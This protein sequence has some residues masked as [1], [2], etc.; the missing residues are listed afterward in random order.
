MVI[1]RLVIKRMNKKTSKVKLKLNDKYNLG[2]KMRSDPGLALPFGLDENVVREISKIK[3]EPKWMLEFRLK[4]YHLF[5][6]KKMPS[7]GADLSKIDFS[8]IHY[9]IKSPDKNTKSWKNVSSEVKK[10][11]DR[12]GI[13]RVEREY[14][15]GVKAQ[16]NSEV[17]YGSLLKQLKDQ[18]VI[19]MSTDEAVQKHPD[20]VRKYIGT[21]IP[22]ADNKFAA[23][24]SAVW[25]GGSFIYI[26]KGAKIE[27][28]LQAYFRINAARMGQFERTL[29]IADEDSFT[30]Y[31]EGCSAPMY[32]ESSI[33]SAVVEIIVKKNARFRYTTV[34]NW[35]KNIY[36]LVTKR[37]YAY[38]NATMEW[39]DGNIGSKV[40]MKY[41]AVYLLGKGAKG[42]VISLAVAKDGQHLDTG[43]KMVHLA[44]NTSSNIISK[45]IS[46]GSGRA[47][48]RGLVKVIGS[49]ENVKSHI[50]C[51]ALLLD[52]KA[53]TDTYPSMEIDNKRTNITHEATVSKVGQDQLFYLMSRGLSKQDASA[54]I[55]NGFIEPVMRELPMEFAVELNQ[56]INLEMEGSVG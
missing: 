12:I 5:V 56:L 26:P 33:H 31:I 3:N 37:A 20:L 13:P 18:G 47:S 45:S 48:Y 22:P 30:Q 23:L 8:K 35:Y 29:I 38:E 9:Y 1:Q 43:A 49:A 46:K 10:T 41:P 4:S 2:F 50:N 16:Y 14:L 11:F 55:V 27:K 28:P 17:V 51:D 21:V 6:S 7:W 24:N 36:N 42:E 32:S 40:T 34:Q 54:L 44:S 52:S 53:R 39:I 15:S 19:F 25:S